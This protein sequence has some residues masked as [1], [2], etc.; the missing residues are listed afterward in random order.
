[1]DMYD[2]NQGM[3]EATLLEAFP[4]RLK[5]DVMKQLNLPTLA[6]MPIFKDASDGMLTSIC[7]VLKVEPC[8]PGDYVIRKGEIGEEMFFIKHGTCEVIVGDP[9]KGKK[10]AEIGPGGF[11]GEVA[12]TKRECRSASIRC[13]TYAE[14]LVLSKQDFDYVT[15]FYTD[16][17]ETLCGVATVRRERDDDRKAP[18]ALPVPASQRWTCVECN[19]VS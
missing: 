4:I 3:D 6:A 11:F 9:E 1:M 15:A 19:F 18:T 7:E 10:V 2:V 16:L 17:Y 14:L 12:L 13:K 8:F 5:R